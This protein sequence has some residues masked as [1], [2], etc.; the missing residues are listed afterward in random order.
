MNHS[1]R[2]VMI[3]QGYYPRIGGAERQLAALIPLLR[4]KGIDVSVITRRYSGMSSYQEIDGVPVYRMPVPGPKPLAS[5]VFTLASLWLLWKL[6]PDVIHAHELLSPTTTALAAKRLFG[7]A[8]VAKVLRGGTLGDIEKLMNKW[9]GPTRLKSFAKNIDA[10]IT[11]SREIDRELVKLNVPPERRPFIPNG[12]D[13]ARFAPV[14]NKQKQTIRTALKMPVNASV[15]IFAGRLSSEKR[16]NLLVDIWPEV[17]RVCGEA[18][19]LIVGEGEERLTLERAAGEGV[20]FA[21]AIDDIAPW[22]KAADVF[23]LPSA[24]EGLSNAL[25]EAMS[26]GLPAIVTSVG[27]APDLI[28]HRENGWLIVPDNSSALLDGIVTLMANA[29]EREVMGLKARE[30]V[31]DEYSLDSVATRLQGLYHN[32]VS[33]KA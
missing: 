33:K 15:A 4:D 14:L 32:V 19:L 7:T 17:R 21:G 18:Y 26:S 27:G 31:K 29:K 9:S 2:V 24:T 22:F 6:R 13:T 3:I 28:N 1:L 10:F 11:I 30:R 23:V 5:L 8:V 25:L 16:V 20:H 12:V